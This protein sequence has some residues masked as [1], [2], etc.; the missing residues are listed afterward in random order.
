M[1]LSVVPLC[2][3]FAL[4]PLPSPATAAPLCA[5]VIVNSSYTGPC[6]TAE[7]ETVCVTREFDLVVVT[8]GVFICVPKVLQGDQVKTAR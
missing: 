5:Q 8:A 7:G 6:V 2:A 3:V 1:R 4:A